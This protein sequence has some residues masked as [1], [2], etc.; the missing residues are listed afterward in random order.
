MRER[1]QRNREWKVAAK[2]GVSKEVVHEK[3]IAYKCAGKRANEMKVGDRRRRADKEAAE[4]CKKGGERAF[5]KYW[6]KLNKKKSEPGRLTRRGVT[7]EQNK[8]KGVLLTEHI[9]ELNVP[10]TGSERDL[11][12]IKVEVGK[13]EKNSKEDL[14]REVEIWEIQKAVAKS[15]W[16]KAKGLDN[17]PNEFLKMGG[18]QLEK[19]LV[20]LFNKVQESKYIPRAWRESRMEM[21]HKGG[22]ETELDNYRGINIASNVGKLF[23]RIYSER[24]PEDVESRGL[25]GEMQ[26]GFR[27]GR[28]TLDAVFV[29]TQMLEKQKKAGKGVA[30]AFL[31]LRKAFDRV[32]REG[33]WK[34][35][36]DLGY[37]GVFL[38]VVKGMYKENRV[39]AKLGDAQSKWVNLQEGLKQGC[40]LSPVLFALYV[41]DLSVKLMESNLGLSWGELRIP[42]V[43]FAD[44]MVIVGETEEQ[45]RKLLRIEGAA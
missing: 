18:G 22:N 34:I 24:L 15:K 28:S 1:E 29:L 6:R 26:F 23:S 11:N 25:L 13:G 9:Q 32:W 44:D 39:V 7:A 10:H 16:G 4:M 35:L 17:I 2:G 31:D 19:L 5:W 38:E 42:G 45:L 41:R 3:W 36:E 30:M 33:M 21:L 37:G 43:F 12:R 14:G 40:N 27:K 20:M 8:D